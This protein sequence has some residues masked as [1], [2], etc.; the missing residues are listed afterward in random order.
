MIDLHLH[1]D[2]SIAKRAMPRMAKLCKYDLPENYKDQVHT[3]MDCESLNEYLNCFNIPIALLQT[4]ATIQVAVKSLIDKLAAQGIIYAEIRFAP[5][6]HMNQGLTMDEVVEADISGLD[7]RIMPAQ[8]IFCC[9]RG[10]EEKVNL[11]VVEVAKKY[12]GKGVCAIDL[13]GAEAIY[14]TKE[15]ENVFKKAQELNIPFTI[16]AGEADDYTSIDKALD[17]GAKRIGHGINAI[18]NAETLK[19][20]IDHRIPLEMCPTSNMQTKAVLSWDKYPLK[21]YLQMGVKATINTD[22]ITVSN[23]SLKL[24]F[25][26]LKDVLK[27]SKEEIYQLLLNAIDAAFLTEDQK[28]K[29]RI[30]MDCNFSYWYY[31]KSTKEE[32]R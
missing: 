29:L 25:E 6:F 22:N 18:Q 15:F 2:G 11:E 19:R 5:M 23:T 20:I 3:S 14:K 16:H 21:K 28:E 13:A 1:L 27:I 4:K 30:R 31:R 26:L 12:L 24:E 7:D 8:I 32:T 10:Q 9:M 17:F